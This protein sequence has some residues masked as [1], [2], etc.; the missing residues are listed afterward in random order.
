[1]YVLGL[2][3]YWGAGARD[4]EWTEASGSTS[5]HGSARPV[6]GEGEGTGVSGR[7]RV[8]RGRES[9][10]WGETLWSE[11]R[12]VRRRVEEKEGW[13]LR[14]SRRSWGQWDPPCSIIVRNKKMLERQLEMW[15]VSGRLQP[16]GHHFVGLL[17]LS[18]LQVPPLHDCLPHLLWRVTSGEV[19]QQVVELC[20]R[21]VLSSCSYETCEH[22][23]QTYMCIVLDVDLQ[24]M[25]D[26]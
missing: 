18:R 8:K 14:G 25:Y 21:Q 13:W 10:W 2:L 12:G 26:N 3:E 7:G 1:M 16:H 20:L 15:G 19:A 4:A 17:L 5:S 24:S 11:W 22:C 9:E 6:E 23:I